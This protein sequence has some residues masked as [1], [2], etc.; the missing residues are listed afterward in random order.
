MNRINQIK[1]TIFHYLNLRWVGS[2]LIV[3]SFSVIWPEFSYAG[4]TCS[5][6]VRLEKSEEEKVMISK[7]IMQ[8][9]EE[10]FTEAEELG[11][12]IILSN[13][14]L[15]EGY[16][17]T[18]VAQFQQDKMKN[19]TETLALLDQADQNLQKALKF[20]WKNATVDTSTENPEDVIT[21]AVVQETLEEVSKKAV[22]FAHLQQAELAENSGFKGKQAEEYFKAWE[23]CPT[24]IDTGYMAAQLLHSLGDIKRCVISLNQI[25]KIAQS[26][27]TEKER[28]ERAADLQRVEKFRG[29]LSSKAQEEYKKLFLSLGERTLTLKKEEKIAI[30]DELENLVPAFS[31]QVAYYRG[32]VLASEGDFTSAI[33]LFIQSLKTTHLSMKDFVNFE[34]TRVPYQV[35][36]VLSNFQFYQVL[37]HS[38][39]QEFIFNY[40]GAYEKDEL[41][42]IVKT[43]RTIVA[44]DKDNI[45]SLASNDPRVTPAFTALGPMYQAAGLIWSGVAPKEMDHYDAEKYC[46]GL[47]TRLPT[48]EEWE[49]LSRAMTIPSGKYNPELLPGTKDKSFWSSSVSPNDAD[50]ACSFYGS[51]G[52]V[53]LYGAYSRKD[54]YYWVR[55]V[56]GT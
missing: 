54:G 22:F 42:E 8:I 13:P 43:V 17:Y 38:E 12:S 3:L 55:C 47:G 29:E 56:R 33:P 50:F 45:V 7:V 36:Q 18:A 15:P 9:Y 49:A 53:D 2:L 34:K 32:W 41:L 26:E 21:Q 28:T 16:Y 25:C 23:T 20:A 37:T 51:N 39:F 48:K 24:H 4:G 14:T 6:L 10:H 40:F 5:R 46:Q 1:N 11:K 31:H 27:L 44:K 30:L 52:N 35:A 19:V